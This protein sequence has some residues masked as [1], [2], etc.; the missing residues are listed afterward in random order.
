MNAGVFHISFFCKE[1]AD[2]DTVVFPAF[3]TNVEKGTL[4]CA[5]FRGLIS[6][7]FISMPLLKDFYHFEEVICN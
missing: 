2:F 7:D 3:S 6:I 5:E 4:T 1:N